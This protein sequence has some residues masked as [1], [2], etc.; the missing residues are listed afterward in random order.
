MRNM[1]YQDI[2][3]SSW[4]QEG[5]GSNGKTYSHPDSPGVLLKVNKLSHNRDETSMKREI[6]MARHVLALLVMVFVI[7]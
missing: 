3:I 7:Y 4:H 1:D 5:E 6:E 2:D